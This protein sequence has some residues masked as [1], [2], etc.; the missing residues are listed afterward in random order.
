MRIGK[1]ACGAKYRM[2]KQSQSFINFL[3]FDSFPNWKNS[4]NL[5]IFEFRKFLKFPIQSSSNF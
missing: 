1:I 3:N 4:E 5:L 2:D